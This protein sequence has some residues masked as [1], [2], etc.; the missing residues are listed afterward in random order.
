M[1]DWV[2]LLV[3]ICIVVYGFWRLAGVVGV[4]IGL[5]GMFV[6]CYVVLSWKFYI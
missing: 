4:V 2:V 6:E 3:A 5:G 1:G